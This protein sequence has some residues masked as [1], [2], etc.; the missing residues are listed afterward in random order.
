MFSL[1]IATMDRYDNF[2]SKYLP[3][4]CQNFMIGEI[5]IG[6]EN[7]HDTKKI[8]SLL[9]CPNKNKIKCFVNETRLGPFRNKLS[10][11]KKSSLSYIALID[12][13]NFADENYFQT[14]LNYITN[15]HLTRNFV[16]M[17]WFA[18]PRF[19]YD[20]PEHF[21]L[22]LPSDQYMICFNTG[23]YVL[24]RDVLFST[25]NTNIQ[26]NTK[27]E[28]ECNKL[29]PVIEKQVIKDKAII[30]HSSAC[31]VILF[32]TILLE[33]RSPSFFVVR[34][35]EYEHTVHD[36]SI[37]IQTFAKEKLYSEAV[38]KRFQNLFISKIDSHYFYVPNKDVYPPFKSGHYLEEYFMKRFFEIQPQTKR[39]YIPA[40][41]TNFQIESWFPSRKSEMQQKLLEWGKKYFSPN[42]FF[43]VIQYDDA[44][45]LQLPP[46][47]V[48][49]G[50]CSGDVPIPLI[51]EDTKNTLPSITKLPF[52]EKSILCS[53]VGS[54]TSNNIQ[55]NVRMEMK[56]LMGINNFALHF[57]DGWTPQVS[58]QNKSLFINTTQKSKFA[59]A[60][61]GYG[62]SSFRFFEVLQM[63]VV[64]IYVWN[65]QIWLPFYDKEVCLGETTCGDK[66]Y[67]KIRYDD[68]CIVL[69]V[70]K[71]D[72][73]PIV[74]NSITETQYLE[75]QNSYKLYQHLFTLEGMTQEIIRQADK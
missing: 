29:H 22:F 43:T 33:T 49:Y 25:V 45:L 61:R 28:E 50:A 24:S 13:D 7:G 20:V 11:L 53:F 66:V 63:G 44:S 56:K 38:Y 30:D 26:P 27:Q 64:P 18:K 31:D 19:K 1:C 6:D 37:Y 68:F 35:L 70:S 23:N 15:N 39:K 34:G 62:R 71:I 54:V 17:P 32:N 41:W 4:Y 42:G 57:T 14:A 74:L 10:T 40:L 3:Q 9:Q 5:I 2:L 75:M 60:P 72:T 8:N 21:S 58:N 46:N 55:P 67:G 52:H 69:H 59:L 51:Y 65:D 47:T 36:G 12:S 48:I 73:L 16:L